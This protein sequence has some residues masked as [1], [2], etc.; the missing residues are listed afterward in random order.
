MISSRG[1]SLVELAICLP[2]VLALG[3]GVPAV[4]RVVDANAGLHAAT[5]A[6]AGAAARAADASAA[7]A[8]AQTRFAAVIALYPV[9]SSSLVVSL[10]DF[11]RGTTI[12]ATATGIVDIGWETMA[13]LPAHI[14]IE[15]KAEAR[16]EPW[17]SR[18]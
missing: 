17:R 16:A 18:P 7:E 6:A 1:Q 13:L 2:V 11:S 14:V 10:D 4:V 5:E 8:T 12:T 9:R 3:L 15:A